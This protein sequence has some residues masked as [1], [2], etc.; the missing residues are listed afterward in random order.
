MIINDQVSLDYLK[1][2]LC[3]SFKNYLKLT[4][5]QT[6]PKRIMEVKTGQICP[7][8]IQAMA[9]R[10]AIQEMLTLLCKSLLLTSESTNNELLTASFKLW[11][12]Y[13]P[14]N[15]TED[16]R[17]NSVFKNRQNNFMISTSSHFWWKFCFLSLTPILALT[18][19]DNV[20]TFTVWLARKSA[21]GW[22]I[23]EHRFPEFLPG[24]PRT[25]RLS[26]YL[27]WPVPYSHY[28]CGDVL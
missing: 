2:F 23:G 11:I 15:Y 14:S 27:S 20:W 21:R 12:Q 8:S 22:E 4:V 26:Q 6:S 16:E 3:Q 18:K 10:H 24:C 17:K 5:N 28:S 1:E 25:Q 7:P 9:S 13:P 19:N